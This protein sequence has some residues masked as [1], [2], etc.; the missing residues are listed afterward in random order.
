MFTPSNSNSFP[1]RFL[2]KQWKINGNEK[3]KKIKKKKSKSDPQ[4]NFE[5]KEKTHSRGRRCC[6]L[7]ERERRTGRSW[8]PNFLNPIYARCEVLWVSVFGFKE[9]E[10]GRL[11][12]CLKPSY[13]ALRDSLSLGATSI[14]NRC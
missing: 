12:F 10:S 14:N 7:A 13:F 5:K 4:S 6:R 1:F 3:L 11:G 8:S 9:P 2:M